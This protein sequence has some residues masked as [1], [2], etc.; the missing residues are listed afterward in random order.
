[1]K[2]ECRGRELAETNKVR[3]ESCGRRKRNGHKNG[4]VRG[5]KDVWIEQKRQCRLQ[6]K[7]SEQQKVSCL[8][9]FCTS[10]MKTSLFKLF[11]R[12]ALWNSLNKWGGTMTS[13]AMF[14]PL[15]PVQKFNFQQK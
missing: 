10:E 6:S 9:H 7:K 15:T 13:T 4:G 3:L 8:T 5:R 12:T 2:F 1:M 14:R 11:F